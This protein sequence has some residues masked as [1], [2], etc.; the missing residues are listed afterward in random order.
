MTFKEWILHFHID[1]DSIIG[2]LAIDIKGDINFPNSKTYKKNS[3]Y[4][5]LKTDVGSPVFEA[6]SEAWENYLNYK[7]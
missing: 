4:L 5:K 1:E 2:D 3:D 7:K 6:F